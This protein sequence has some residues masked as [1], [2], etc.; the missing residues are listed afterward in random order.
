M[1]GSLYVVL[2]AIA[3]GCGGGGG[4]GTGPA[5]LTSVTVSPATA[6]LFTAPPGTT[7]QFTAAA[8]DQNGR[9]ITSG[10][11]TTWSSDDPNVV[12]IDPNTGVATEVASG[13]PVSIH[14]T[15]TQGS[16]SKSGAA[17]VTVE[18]A[19]ATAEVNTPGLS[20]SPASVDIKAGG[21]VTWHIRANGTSHN[22]VMDTQGAPFT[23]SG[24]PSSNVDFTSPAFATPGTYNYHCSV[25]GSSM[26]GTVVVH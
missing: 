15:V 7:Q 26:S 19:P 14:A 17:S 1:R 12:S 4:G 21:T 13:G 23:N 18:D 20:F 25:H 16:A 6:S 10:I 3:L 8:K 5:T 22:V 9:A 2:A 24:T 11:T